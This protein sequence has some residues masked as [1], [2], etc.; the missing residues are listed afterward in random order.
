M[1][2]GV[3][4][5]LAGTVATP[6]TLVPAYP[7]QFRERQDTNDS[8]EL[9]FNLLS[10]MRRGIDVDGTILSGAPEG[11]AYIVH[12]AR[13]GMQAMTAASKALDESGFPAAGERKFVV[14]GHSKWGGAA[15]QIAAVDDRLV[16]ALSFGFPLDWE[17]FVNLAVDRWDTLFGV[18]LF[19]FRCQKGDIRCDWTSD[20][21]ARFFASTI[22]QP[23]SCN[24][25][26]CPGTG[27]H[28]L[29]QLDIGTLRAAG[30]HQGVRFALLRNGGEAHPVDTEANVAGTEAFP[31]QFLLLSESGHTLR[32]DAHEAYWHHWIRHCFGLGETLTIGAPTLTKH[33]RNTIFVAR[34]TGIQT[35][36]PH[37]PLS[38]DVQ[39]CMNLVLSM[40][41][42]GI[43][44]RAHGYVQQ[45]L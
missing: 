9:L 22:A 38:T 2:T 16:G 29:R 42:R 44:V 18:D 14:G 35:R 26:A 24:L 11:R 5:V 10:E 6:G 27:E 37:L 12:I 1:R 32:S 15:A 41:C 30:H 40:E 31:D 36:L 20:S 4:C 25:D 3:T 8:N 45:P 7:A 17:R 34:L 13:A 33:L 39:Q 19:S 43:R 28:W 21:V 23:E